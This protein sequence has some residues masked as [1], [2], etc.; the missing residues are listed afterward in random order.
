[1]KDK[2]LFIIDFFFINLGLFLTGY[3]LCNFLIPARLAAGGVS[4]LSTII[5]YLFSIPIGWSMFI[6]NIPIFILGISTF[7]RSY[8]LKS[9]YGIVMLSTYSNL[10][11]SH[12]VFE[13]FAFLATN[14][15]VLGS[16]LWGVTI[17]IGLG[18]ALGFGSNTG[19]T[20][21]IAQ[22]LNKHFKLKVGTCLM[23]A[24]AIVVSIAAMVFDIKSALLAG[25][26][27]LLMGQVINFIVSFVQK[28]RFNSD[29]SKINI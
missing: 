18:F 7:G 9:I 23:I 25:V 28:T 17:G 27:L 4:G 29:G 22:V 26:S 21:I 11:Q 14:N 2:K 3:G 24:D 15:Q 1:M 10:V 5:Y 13:K 19:G 16:T 20:A 8:A 12:F 6:I